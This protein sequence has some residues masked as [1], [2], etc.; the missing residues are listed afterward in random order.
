M[1]KHYDQTLPIEVMFDQ[2]EEGIEVVESASCPYNKNQI[3][4]KAY[5]LILQTG[6]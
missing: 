1:I 3:L 4:Q 6:K 5:L 2:I